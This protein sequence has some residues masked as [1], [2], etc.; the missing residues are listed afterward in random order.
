MTGMILTLC[1]CAAWGQTWRGR[2]RIVISQMKKGAKRRPDRACANCGMPLGEEG[3]HRG[4][5]T[6]LFDGAGGGLAD[7]IR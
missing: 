7:R 2:V 1:L 5:L 6:E 3:Q 4:R